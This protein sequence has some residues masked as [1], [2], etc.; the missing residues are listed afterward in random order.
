MDSLVVTSGTRP[1]R[2]F[3]EKDRDYHAKYA[4]WALNACHDSYHQAFIRKTTINWNFY[5]G[6]QWIYD[7]DLESFLMDESG[8]VRNRIKITQNLV[9]PIVEQYVGNAIRMNF[10]AKAVGVSE[11]VSNRRETAMDQLRMVHMAINQA[12][13][14]EEY[15]TNKYP[16]DFVIESFIAFAY[17]EL[18]S[19]VYHI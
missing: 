10:N 4:R 13:E 14:T 1:N 3:D 16:I 6:N 5:K 9:R 8:D 12:P 15:F 19:D 17:N 18:P 7:E 2:L 11:F